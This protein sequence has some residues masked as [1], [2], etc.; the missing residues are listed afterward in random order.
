MGV[1]PATRVE[2]EFKDEEDIHA[3]DNHTGAPDDHQL[4]LFLLLLLTWLVVVET[5][6]LSS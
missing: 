3:Q 4:L 5:K 1:C 2:D 6:R